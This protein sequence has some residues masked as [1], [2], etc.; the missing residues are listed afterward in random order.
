MAIAGKIQDS[1][2]VVVDGLAFSEPK[3]SQMASVLKAL[4]LN[5]QTTL[6]T[7]AAYDALVYKSARNI[8]GVSI[9]PVS[10][11]NALSVLKPQRMLVTKDAMDAIKA[12]ANG[13]ATT[14]STEA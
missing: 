1:Q 11:L 12:G 13:A 3:T 2:V 8:A 6:V 14:E 5:G 9:S 10:D 7:T 4:N